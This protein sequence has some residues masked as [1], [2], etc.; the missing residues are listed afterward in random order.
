MALPHPLHVVEVFANI[1]EVG[2]HLGRLQ[3]Q[4]TRRVS[5]VADVQKR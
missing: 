2:G 3:G 1:L 5:L 4:L